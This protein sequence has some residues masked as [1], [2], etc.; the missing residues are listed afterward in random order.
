MAQEWNI[1]PRGVSCSACEAAFADGQAYFT[2]L[3]FQGPDYMRGDFCATCWAAEAPRSAGYSSWKGI[4]H[5]PPAE[6]ERRVGKEM[7]EF[8]LRDLIEANDPSRK[9]VIY[10]LAV[11]LE[12]QRVFVERDVKT[13][14]DGGR[15]VVYEHRR[16]GESF[17]ITDPRLKLSEIEPLQQEI[18]I[19]LTGQAADSPPAPEPLAPCSAG[20]GAGEQAQDA[21]GSP[22]L[23]SN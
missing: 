4:F 16:T 1:R 19:L 12:R 9:R 20:D 8:L 15:V 13:L 22:C 23:T 7:A 10:I 14:E 2:R 18:M 5:V 11:M 3:T 21:G 6:P 17:P